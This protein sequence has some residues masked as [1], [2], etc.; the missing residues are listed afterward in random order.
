MKKKILMLNRR[1]IK[2][3]LGGGAEV[4]T[5][6][7]FKRLTDYYDITYITSSFINAKEIDII[8]NIKY[9]RAGG[10][11]SMHI[12][13]FIYY[14]K[15]KSKFD[16]IIDQFN[17]LGF[18]TFFSKNSIMLIHQ[19]YD[20]FWVSKLGKIGYLFKFIEKFLLF[21]YKR[22]KVIVVS[23][24]TKED[25]I[26]LGYKSENIDIIYNGIDFIEY[27]KKENFQGNKICYLGRMEKTKNPEDVLKTLKILK[28]RI[29][30]LEL[31]F[32]GGG[33][34]NERLINE[35]GNIKNVKFNGFVSE[36]DKYKILRDSDLLIVPSIREGWGQIV[37]QAN[38]VA[39]PVVG[40]RVQGIKDSV[41]HGETGILVE[42]NSIKELS[43]AIYNLLN[44]KSKLKEFSEKALNRAKEF[45]WNNSAKSM[46]TTL[47]NYV[48]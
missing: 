46:N 9:I 41:V 48:K 26:S 21:F 12:Y 34:E 15:N 11:M 7:I 37:I 13:A 19:L 10:E 36:S 42:P 3:P 1:C 8:D 22:K 40:Y 14:L 5:H 43:E 32:V 4:Y 44:D 47:K 18:L 6:E 45:S 30:N 24:S 31:N 17:G 33:S 16:I 28:E 29:P 38:M 27:N 2:N 23:E 20:E 25:L 39:T 35:Y